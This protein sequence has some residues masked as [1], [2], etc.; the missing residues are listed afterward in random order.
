MSYEKCGICGEYDFVN[1]H[2]CKPIFYVNHPD[3]NGDDWD[4]IRGSYEED[5]AEEYGRKYNENGDYLLMNE[6]I[7]ICVSQYPDGKDAKKFEVSAEPDIHYRVSE[8]ES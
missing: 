2:K 4:K 1:R 6:T 3:Y 7:T 8:I 5:A